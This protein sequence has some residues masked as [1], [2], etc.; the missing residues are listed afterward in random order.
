MWWQFGAILGLWLSIVLPVCAVEAIEAQALMSG[1]ALLRI[2]GVQHMLRD[3]QRSPEG[4][5]LVSADSR[6]AIIEIDGKRRE[7]KLSQRIS[8]NFTAPDT[9]EVRIERDANAQYRT[10][11]SINGHLT[12]VMVDTGANMVAL[13]GEQAAMLGI[14]YHRGTPTYVSTASGVARAYSIELDSVAVGGVTASYIPA[15][16]IEGHFPQT[17]LLGMSFLQRVGMHEENG[18]LYLKQ[19]F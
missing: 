10:T 5:L 9:S 8:G 19:K 1:A 11:A 18:A 15:V 3:G 7:L 6:H 16:V 17:V 4:V 12:T 2:D 14:E 13:S